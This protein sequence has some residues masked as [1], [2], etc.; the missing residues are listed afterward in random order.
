[1]SQEEAHMDDMTSEEIEARVKGIDDEIKTLN[2]RVETIQAEIKHA[3]R[4]IKKLRVE[5][6]GKVRERRELAAF[7]EARD[8]LDRLRQMAQT[9]PAL[10]IALE[11]S[12][13]LERTPQTPRNEFPQFID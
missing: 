8:Q 6:D 9:N 13:V 1:M 11:E 7:K 10:R 5:K 12:G 2:E 4:Q 3:R